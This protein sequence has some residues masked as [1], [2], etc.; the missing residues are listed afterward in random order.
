MANGGIN[1]LSYPFSLND[2]SNIQIEYYNKEIKFEIPY[3]V[4]IKE[5]SKISNKNL[6]NHSE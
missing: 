3:K 5:I 2:L 4:L 6:I 1:I